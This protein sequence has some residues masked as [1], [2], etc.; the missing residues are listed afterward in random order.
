MRD[1]APGPDRWLD[2]LRMYLAVSAVAHLIWETLQVPL[3]T[4]WATGTARDI[5][6][7]VSHCTGGDVL[8]AAFSLVAA[9]ALFGS[10]H[11]PVANNARVF[12]TM[13]TFGVGY[14]IYSEWLNTTK[15]ASW[16]YSD[17]MPVLPVIGTGLS[18]ALQW[19]VVPLIAMRIA[20]G[21]WPW[22]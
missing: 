4:L 16:A 6:F 8:I 5:A 22:R 17:L 19:V 13:T 12:A 18:P 9:L 15:R 7:A 20:T 3:Y 21:V 1:V 14:T 2:T 11:W 10:N